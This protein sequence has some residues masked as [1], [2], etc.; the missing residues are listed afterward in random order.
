MEDPPEQC[1]GVLIRLSPRHV[2]QR[3]GARGVR[4][5]EGGFLSTRAYVSVAWVFAES[6]FSPNRDSRMLTIATRA[7]GT[8]QNVCWAYVGAWTR[9]SVQDKVFFLF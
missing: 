5:A 2:W 4:A 3:A 1:R 6:L 7:S 9:K 8:F